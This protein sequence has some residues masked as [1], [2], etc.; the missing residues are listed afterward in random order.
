M[1]DFYNKFLRIFVFIVNVC[2]IIWVKNE[3]MCVRVNTY[4]WK[5]VQ[6]MNV[7]SHDTWKHEQ[8]YMFLK[9]LTFTKMK[10]IKCLYILKFS[11]FLQVFQNSYC[12]LI[13]KFLKTISI[14]LYL[15]IYFYKTTLPA[16]FFPFCPPVFYLFSTCY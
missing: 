4:L 5:L 13:Q 16:R 2:S 3:Q 10:T 9:T 7:C 6:Y 8:I 14:I 15:Y 11:Y 1:F 12:K